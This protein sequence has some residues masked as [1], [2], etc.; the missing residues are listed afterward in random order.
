VLIT[1]PAQGVAVRTLPIRVWP[2]K[3]GVQWLLGARVST[4]DPTGTS[5]VLRLQAVARAA[6]VS[7]RSSGDLFIV[8][9][10]GCA[11]ITNGS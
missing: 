4:G 7:K 6:A 1:V 8:Y 5:S 10:L 11:C 3:A 9:G 2:V